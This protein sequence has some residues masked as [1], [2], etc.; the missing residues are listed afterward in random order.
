MPYLS[1]MSIFDPLRA[2]PPFHA[3]VVRQMSLP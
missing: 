1:C 3:V 2:E